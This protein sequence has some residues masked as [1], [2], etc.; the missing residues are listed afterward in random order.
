MAQPDLPSL[1][2]DLIAPH[3]PF[4]AERIASL[5]EDDW[6]A[7]GVMAA[8]H[9]LRPMLHRRL[10]AQGA[11]DAV[12]DAMRAD[13]AAS[14]HRGALRSLTLQRDL[15]VLHDLLHET[16][17]PYLAL[18]GAYLAWH[19][20]P[21]PGLRPLRD[22]DLLVPRDRAMELFERL[23]D[24]GYT[25]I[26]RYAGDPQ[27]YLETSHQLPPLMGPAGANTVEIHTLI[28]HRDERRCDV[29]D[30]AEDPAYW[31]R[32]VER[33]MGGRALCFPSPEDILIH[34]IEHAVYGHQFD[35]GPL[36][37]SDIAY[38]IERHTIDWP[39]F[40]RL[41]DDAACRRGAM[42]SLAL[43]RRYWP[44][45]AIGWP[46]GKADDIPEAV[47]RA[48]ARASL[49]SGEHRDS[50]HLLVHARTTEGG[51]RSAAHIWRRL[52]PE[53]NNIA[54]IYPVRAHSPLIVYYY[55]KRLWTL[56][57]ERLPTV[58]ARRSSET[59]DGLVL[60]RRWL[61]RHG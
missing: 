46:E 7:I 11:I 23:L 57:T 35:N 49:R 61:E 30:P 33:T 34:L 13:W 58:I 50:D 1:L 10:A 42:L 5:D 22:L 24:R 27:A 40:W 3:R 29:R 2:L 6:Q 43:V 60:I 56:A 31:E 55:L 15:M 25:R 20:Y 44:D 12:P 26:A 36:L 32:K 17:I 9:R 28:F 14:H 54:L 38:L 48:A 21:E 45:T 18:K 16:G 37:L 51:A 59:V 4:P 41:A 52:F 47:L 53:R 39:L 19:A 8:E